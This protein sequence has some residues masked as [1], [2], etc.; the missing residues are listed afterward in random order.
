MA[1]RSD[2]PRE[3]PRAGAARPSA[4][5]QVLSVRETMQRLRRG[6]AAVTALIDSGALQTVTLG[7]RRMVVAESVDR[8]LGLTSGTEVTPEALERLVSR[9]LAD[10]LRRLAEALAAHA[11]DR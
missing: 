8:L 4:A 6:H 5:P 10:A 3:A 9:R 1:A 7:G 2:D 11:E